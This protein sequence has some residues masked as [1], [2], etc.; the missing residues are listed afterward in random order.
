MSR[1]QGLRFRGRRLSAQTAPLQAWLG[2]LVEAAESLEAAD[3]PWIAALVN[4]TNGR[5]RVQACVSD[6]GMTIEEAWTS[7][8]LAI[9]V[10]LSEN[11]RVKID[12]RSV[13][14]KLADPEW[15]ILDGLVVADGWDRSGPTFPSQVVSVADGVIA[16]LKGDLRPDPPGG[17]WMV[18]AGDGT[19][20]PHLD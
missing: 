1:W 13:R 9:V 15:S 2:L 12:S 5:W 8:Q 4:P 20:T 17:N 6:F 10:R 14:A 7:E 16:L 3:E 19:W 18:G 11:V